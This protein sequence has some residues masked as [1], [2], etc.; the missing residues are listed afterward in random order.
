M[1]I[2]YILKTEFNLEINHVEN[3]IKLIDDGNTIPFIARYRKEMTGSIDDQKLRELF[4]RLRYLRNLEARKLEIKFLISEQ[5]NLD[6]KIS[7]SINSSITL[8]E[9][10]D[11]YRPFKP[12]R[13]TKA[14]IARDKGITPL[15]DIILT[16][17]ADVFSVAKNYLDVDKEVLDC[18]Q[19]I[20]YALYIIAEYISDNFEI[21]KKLREFIYETGIIVTKAVDKDKDSVYTMY[22]D[23]KESVNKIVS[24][25]VLAINRAEKEKIIKVSISVDKKIAINIIK[26]YFLNENNIENKIYIENACNDSFDRL[27]FPSIEREIRKTLTN[28][29][30]DKSIKVFSNNLKQ[31]IM[32]PPLKGYN[33]IGIDPGYR[34]GC[35]IC[36]IDDTGK[37]LD[38]GVVY[39]TPPNNKIEQAEYYILDLVKKYNVN[40]F[41]IGN[42]TASRESEKFISEFIKKYN[43]DIKYVIVNEAGASVYSV[44]KI[45]VEEFPDYDVSIRGAFSIAR[46]LQ[47]PLSEL[48]KIDAKSIGVG[49]YQHDMDKSKLDSS[50]NGV[51]EYCVN[52]VGVNLNTSSYILLSKVSG[53]TTS[54]A[55]NIISY[56]EKNGPFKNRSELL[57][58][59]K[60]GKKTYEQCAGFLK[61]Y[62]GDNILDATFVHP[63]SYYYVEKL[64]ELCYNKLN[65]DRGLDLQDL[66]NK[67]DNI[68]YETLSDKIGVGV[69]TLK[70]IVSELLKPGRDPRDDLP[71]PI[72]KS[73]IFDI[74][75]LKVGMVLDGTVRNLIDFGAFVDI[76][77]HYDGL[78]H[79]SKMSNSFVSNPIDIINVGDIVTVKII[80][81]DL[82]KNRIYLSL[83][84]V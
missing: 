67:I 15:A 84:D 29:A 69:L 30:C 50:L 38:H 56:R 36:V 26:E 44:S 19:A 78:I 9:L 3:I 31:L 41:S 79:I 49:Q 32:Q 39:F 80:D 51:I 5:E 13:T 68:G 27:I 54:I 57:F 25:R 24:H 59:N 45:A 76:G 52:S 53:L 55:K 1:D 23:Y 43:L 65:Y 35:K 72:L 75:D 83:I 34:T 10:E 37:A 73:D 22:Y 62:G 21:R 7:N 17:N 14:S 2:K 60:L 16:Q 71:K 42:G 46:R 18:E 70:D 64:L 47:D 61:I 58:V 82:I 4:D 6:E 74:S 33:I 28:L 77:V 81:L 11:I 63:E 12:K 8:S 20:E 40:V 48:V 66:K